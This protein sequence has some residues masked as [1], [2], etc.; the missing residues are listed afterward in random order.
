M[1]T[2]HHHWLS[3]G[4]RKVR[5]A[6]KEKDLDFEAT[7]EKPWE[8]RPE[9][10][11]LNPA[12]DVP[13]L[14]EPHGTVLADAQAICEFLE[15]VYPQRPLMPRDAPAR[16]EVRR[17][18]GWFDGKFG[19]EVTD[20]LVGE[21][22]IKRMTRR[23]TPN[24]A[25]IRTGLS[26]L[27]HHLDYIGHLA[28][29]RRWLGGEDFSLADIAAAAHLSTVDYIGDVPWSEF[30][31]AKDW[32]ARIKS[33]PSFRTILADHVPGAPPPAHYADLDF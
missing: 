8:A 29:R 4:A 10:L 2:L 28:E 19:R 33:R 5:I 17:L 7:I 32:Y 30:D 16:A 24:S 31:A 3:A 14:V 23:E 20:N 15:E 6:L 12:G 22:M 25:L 21:K 26:A 1:R 18:V 27:R 13:V 11:A 9:F